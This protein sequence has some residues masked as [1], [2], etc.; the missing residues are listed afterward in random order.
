MLNFNDTN[1]AFKV[2]SNND[3]K[4][5]YWLFRIIGSP[6]IVKLGKFVM[7]IALKLRIPVN[8][9]VKKTIFKQ[10]CGGETI[11]ECTPTIKTLSKFNIGTILD[12]SVE[13]KIEEDDFD[14]TTEIII[15]TIEKAA[16]G[17]DILF[18]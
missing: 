15:Q 6:L 9:I 7:I 18:T 5:A 8:F 13:G 17:N 11:D 10:F 1:V 4:R 3:L 14:Q 16:I 12:Y 2:K